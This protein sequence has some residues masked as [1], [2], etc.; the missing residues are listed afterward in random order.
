MNESL[1]SDFVKFS[2]KQ[3]E[4]GDID[5]MYSILESVFKQRNYDE[6][7]KLWY[8]FL[9]TTFYHVGSAEILFDKY[10]KLTLIN[11]KD[12]QSMPTG[13]ERRG[14]RG[15]L[16]WVDT[17]ND[18]ALNY[19]S[20]TD[21]ISPV[22]RKGMPGWKGMRIQF[23]TIR[24]NGPW[25][26]YKFADLLA[27][28]MRYDIQADDLGNNPAVLGCA[29]TLTGIGRKT[30]ERTISLQNELFQKSLAAGI[31][32][33]GLDQLETC[34]CDFHSA[35]NGHYYVGHDIDMNMKQIP[36]KDEFW[37]ARE[38]VFDSKYL[39]EKNAWSGERKDLKKRYLETGE[40]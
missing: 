6:E 16:N 17:V 4:S 13:I 38:E 3:L 19:S 7:Q 24:N 30:I 21:F 15:N 25:S 39:G 40:L 35:L 31:T 8:L 26:S 22:N 23:E 1:F 5:P 10:P 36:N 2:N 28:V 9:Y 27:H 34:L 18:L 33:S 29:E 11:K 20:M 12:V 37:K 14:F 32:F